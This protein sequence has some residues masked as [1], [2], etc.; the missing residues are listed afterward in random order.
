MNIYPGERFDQRAFRDPA[1][2]FAVTYMWFWNVPVSRELIDRELD[3]YLRAGVRSLY[4]V[5]LPIDFRPETIRTF[6]H[7]EYL[8]E[9]FFDLV[10]YTLRRCV[11]LGIT[12]WIYDEGGWPSGGACGN[13]VREDKT[14]LIKRLVTKK[15]T[16]RC[17][18][19]FHPEAGFLALFNG[20]RRLPDDYI[21][22]GDVELTAYYVSESVSDGN[23]VD[24][25]S[26]TATDT[27][28]SNTHEKYKARVGDL[29]GKDLPI[30]FT[31]EPGLGAD[32]L[33]EGEV[34][35]F[36]EEFGY[37][38]LD[39]VYVIT[40]SGENCTTEA[41]RQA[42]IDHFLLM[43][44]QFKKNTFEKLRDW[45][46]KNGVYYSG[47]LDCDNRPRGGMSMGLFSMIDALRYFHVPGIDVIWEQIRY[48]HGARA[49]IDDET[50]N[51]RFF[52]RLAPSAARQEGRCVSVTESLGIYGDGLT[53][54]E[55]RYVIGYQMIRGINA[56]NF[57]PISIGSERNSC[58][59][60]RPNFRPEKP[61]F[62]N[63]RQM[64]EYLARLSYLYRLGHS[65]GDTALYMPC[66]DYCAGPE[67]LDRATVSF[68]NAG[69]ALE[70]ENVSFDLIDD[71]V[72]RDSTDTGDG[73]CIG[74]AVYRHVV[75]PE[76][77]YMP[78]D[79][80]ERIAPYVGSG[81]PDLPLRS[82]AL[83]S[84]TRS[85]GGDRL[86]FIFNEGEATVTERLP[87]PKDKRIY[88]L[89]PVS[90]DIT[91]ATDTTCTLVCGETAVYLYTD[92]ILDAVNEDVEFSIPV[93]GFSPVGHK[94]FVIEYSGVKNEYGDG[95][96]VVDENFSGEITYRAKYSLPIVPRSNERYAIRLDGFSASACVRIG[97]REIPLGMTPMVAI[98]SGTDMKQSGEI[99]I[100]VANTAL[101]E[102]Y[103]K[104]NVINSH[105]QAEVGSYQYRME[106][107]E[108]RRPPL[109]FGTVTIEKFS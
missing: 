20:K 91:L 3:S 54:D 11:T 73:L 16:L 71:G 17:D 56:I 107:I 92:E 47:H 29:F 72:V 57:A 96:V 43:G 28:I 65:T 21:A 78:D 46:E 69:A 105:P 1:N 24:Y 8:S 23:R 86:Y 88:R 9:E 63:L 25:T 15:V 98:V 102:I 75:V 81:R 19:R 36:R 70:L 103:A 95:H 45:C 6:L 82:N 74:D 99:E 109:R 26:A 12:P 84:M 5:P 62:N 10:E 18:E 4:I 14:S 108:S 61:G 59:L 83:R 58:L 37:D 39:Y 94:R 64:N 40:G 30:V 35:L 38:I 50:S 67:H 27:F 100:T 89:D 60:T 44:K 87:L 51:F 101:N 104:M 79:V 33:A 97:E 22:H 77:R 80:R 68:G 76:N 55:I 85:L 7:P 13:T 66:R 49:P 52:P 90:G 34:E 2:E 106:P 93:T 53:H 48:P 32:T 31:D 42:R 41:E